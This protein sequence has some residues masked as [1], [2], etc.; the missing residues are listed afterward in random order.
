MEKHPYSQQFVALTFAT[1]LFTGNLSANL[2]PIKFYSMY[3]NQLSALKDHDPPHE[4]PQPESTEQIRELA[5]TYITAASY[6]TRAL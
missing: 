6:S 3:Q 2:E 1:T 4:N 5:T